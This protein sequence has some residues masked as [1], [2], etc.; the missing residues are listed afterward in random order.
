MSAGASE[1]QARNDI[2]TLLSAAGRTVQDLAKLNLSA[3]RGVAVREMR[4]QGGP[5]DYILFADGANFSS[6]L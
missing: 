2:D 4:S 6:V 1:D 3:S 5:V